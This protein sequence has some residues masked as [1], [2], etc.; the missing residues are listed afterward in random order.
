MLYLVA[1]VLLAFG[2]YFV[3][4]DL[5][6]LWVRH[7]HRARAQGIVSLERTIEW[8]STTRNSGWALVAGGILIL[9]LALVIEAIHGGETQ[10]RREGT[11]RY[12]IDGKQ[13]SEQEARRL[14]LK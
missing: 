8:E 13:I 12:S 10:A 5:E 1:G 2:V 14:G 6:T 7:E 4:T 9:F 3:A 11:T